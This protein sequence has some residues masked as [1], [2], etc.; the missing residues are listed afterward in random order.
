M[1]VLVLGLNGISKFTAF[2]KCSW[3]E[4]LTSVSSENNRQICNWKLEGRQRLKG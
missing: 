2:N 3:G 1:R 4:R